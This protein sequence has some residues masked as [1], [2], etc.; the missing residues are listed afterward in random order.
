MNDHEIDYTR[1]QNGKQKFGSPT[2]LVVQVDAEIVTDTDGLELRA[3]I[4]LSGKIRW[5]IVEVHTRLASLAPYVS[6]GHS[7]HD[8]RGSLAARTDTSYASGILNRWHQHMCFIGADY[9]RGVNGG[10]VGLRRA[11]RNQDYYNSIPHLRWQHTHT[12]T[13]KVGIPMP[14]PTPKAILSLALY[15]PLG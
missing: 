2:T 3:K 11:H 1:L 9:H 7:A 12:V 5:G 10:H 4:Q 13:S 8:S 15:P 14:L 6:P